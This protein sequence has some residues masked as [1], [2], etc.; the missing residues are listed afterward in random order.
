MEDHVIQVN[1]TATCKDYVAT[2]SL[3][4]RVWVAN[5][6]LQKASLQSLAI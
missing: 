4:N 5:S 2:N 6:E 3:I 1:H